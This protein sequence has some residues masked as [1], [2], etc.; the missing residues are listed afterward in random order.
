MHVRR[1]KR[2]TWQN[3]EIISEGCPQFRDAQREEW[4]QR[5]TQDDIYSEWTCCVE[6]RTDGQ[7]WQNAARSCKCRSQMQTTASHWTVDEMWFIFKTADLLPD[8]F[9]C[10]D[11]CVAFNFSSFNVMKKEKTRG[12]GGW[13]P[14][15]T[16]QM[17]RNISNDEGKEESNQRWA[18]L[19]RDKMHLFYTP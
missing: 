1:C 3:E 5:C 13:D 14:I 19:F 17:L 10:G 16:N 6:Q 7:S 12:G 9:P 2:E 8:W 18:V 11:E 4:G 15:T